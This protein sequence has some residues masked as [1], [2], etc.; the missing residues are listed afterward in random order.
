[1]ASQIPKFIRLGET[2]FNP[3]HITSIAMKPKGGLGR[4]GDK[5][6][7]EVKLSTQ[8][9]Y[10]SGSSTW[11]SGEQKRCCYTFE[12]LNRKTAQAWVDRKFGE[13]IN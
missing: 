1:M 13:H 12:F 2:W 6:L 5:Y 9:S 10:I 8:Q 4:F 7:V 3:M 11:F